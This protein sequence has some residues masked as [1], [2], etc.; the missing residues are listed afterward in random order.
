MEPMSDHTPLDDSQ[1]YG[2]LCNSAALD[3]IERAI[4]KAQRAPLIKLQRSAADAYD[5]IPNAVTPTAAEARAAFGNAYL[6]TR[7]V[8]KQNQLRGIAQSIGLMPPA[9]SAGD[10]GCAR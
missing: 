2:L 10:K 9:I 1:L 8:G 7:D 4:P 3:I 5:D 6:H